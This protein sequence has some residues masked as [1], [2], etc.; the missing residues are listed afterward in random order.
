MPDG[1]V[2][3]TEM[4][5]SRGQA[6]LRGTDRIGYYQA[7]RGAERLTEPAASLTGFRAVLVQT[8]VW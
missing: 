7:P 8:W 6:G 5:G 4:R 3:E 1:Y 2:A